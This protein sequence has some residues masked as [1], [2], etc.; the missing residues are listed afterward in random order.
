M[1]LVN[2]ETFRKKEIIEIT[3]NACNFLEEGRE[4]LFFDQIEILLVSKIPFGKLKPL[5]EYLGKRGLQNPELYF[6]VLDNFFK[7]NIDYGYRPGLYNTAKMKMSDEEVQKSRVWGWRA[8]IV[9]LAFNE[10]SREHP[11][12]V[13]DKTREYILLSSHWSSSDTFADK[14]FNC[15]FKERFPYIIG[16]LKSWVVDEND[17]IRNAATFSVHAP[18][19]NKIITP[20]QF[21]ELLGVLDLVMED[22]AKNV[23]KKAAWA[24]KVISKYYPDETYYFLEKWVN[25]DN[26]D[27]KWI[28]KNSL[29]YL[30]EKRRIELLEKMGTN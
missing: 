10:M 20:E 24:L 28:I 15:L 9:G 4:D 22:S 14:T 11:E 12:K 16:V 5:G 7:K 23:Q 25:T 27:T 2:P 29:K 3:K 26:K 8:G 13:V 18:V 6:D 19:E 17:W 1:K 21:I 30:D